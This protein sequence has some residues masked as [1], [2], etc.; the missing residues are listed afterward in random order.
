MYYTTQ[1]NVTNVQPIQVIITIYAPMTDT[2]PCIMFW[3]RAYPLRG[4]PS[5][6]HPELIRNQQQT[7]RCIKGRSGNYQR[8]FKRD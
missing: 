6:P 3:M 7:V 8:F 1:K 5:S 2:A 4:Y